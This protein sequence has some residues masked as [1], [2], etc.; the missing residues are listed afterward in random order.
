MVAIAAVPV[1]LTAGCGTFGIGARTKFQY[2]VTYVDTSGG[3][4]EVSFTATD[5]RIMTAVVQLPWESDPIEVSGSQTYVV[6]GKADARITAN[7]QCGVHT[8]DGLNLFSTDSSGEC[9]YTF[10]P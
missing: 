8:S 6:R 4:A 9:N 1:L 7:L 2:R 3:Q 10:K 5:G